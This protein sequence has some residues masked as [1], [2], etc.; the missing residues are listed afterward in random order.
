MQRAGSKR[1]PDMMP[2]TIPVIAGR[3]LVNTVLP[4]LIPAS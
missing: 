1:E 3:P 2:D 4:P